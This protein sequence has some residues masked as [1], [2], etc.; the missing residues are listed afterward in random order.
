[1]NQIENTLYALWETGELCSI[2]KNN[3]RI[4]SADSLVKAPQSHD[5][6][7]AFTPFNIEDVSHIY[8]NDDEIQIHLKDEDKC[9][10]EFMKQVEK[11]VELLFKLPKC[12]ENKHS[13]CVG[14]TYNLYR[15]KRLVE[16]QCS[17]H[18]IPTTGEFIE[19]ASSMYK[20]FSASVTPKTIYGKLMRY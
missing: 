6:M 15:D 18:R 12:V 19:R 14:K 1:M 9:F 2:Y 17:C 7:V 13:E 4:V 10:N 3:C 11:E 5:F 20:T 8:I 16:C